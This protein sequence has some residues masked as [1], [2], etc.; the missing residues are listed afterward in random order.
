MTP[1]GRC[2]VHRGLHSQGLICLG[3]TEVRLRPDGTADESRLP[4]RRKVYRRLRLR[5]HDGVVY[6][7]RWGMALDWLGG[8]MLHTMD[9]PDP[10]RDLHD[11]PWWFVSIILWGGYTE[12]RC[13]TES[14]PRWAFGAEQ[15]PEEFPERGIV[16][17]RRVGSVRVMRLDECHTVTELTRSR[18][19]SLVIRGPKRR[20]RDAERAP[21]G[22]YLP[23]GWV[24]ERTY[25]ET[26]RAERRDL[27]NERG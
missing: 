8:F 1:T 18:S 14:A 27:W 15:W 20:D 16:E 12:E 4:G 21:W 2:I 24:D 11:H 3:W 26:V 5:R 22:F 19:V 13:A 10:G 23:W 17:R 6:L 25:D 9:G 7:D